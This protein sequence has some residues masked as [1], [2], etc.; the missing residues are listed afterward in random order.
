M[1][2]RLHRYTHSGGLHG[3]PRFGQWKV[4]MGQGSSADAWLRKVA[5]TGIGSFQEIVARGLHPQKHDMVLWQETC[6]SGPSQCLAGGPCVTTTK[7]HSQSSVE[8]PLDI[9]DWTSFLI[10]RLGVFGFGPGKSEIVPA[11]ARILT[12]ETSQGHPGSNVT[13]Y[14]QCPVVN[15]QHPWHLGV[16]TRED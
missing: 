10:S 5:V 6:N 7:I 4:C 14:F 12:R 13:R 16:Y 1:E 15:F 11:K 8:P 3:D 2:A 9:T